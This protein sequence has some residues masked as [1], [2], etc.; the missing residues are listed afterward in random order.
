MQ[1]GVVEELQGP[2]CYHNIGAGSLAVQK[3]NP[4]E[5]QVMRYSDQCVLFGHCWGALCWSA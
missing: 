1:V 2:A 4:T 5:T 3:S